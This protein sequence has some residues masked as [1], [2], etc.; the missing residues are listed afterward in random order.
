[1]QSALSLA[2]TKMLA[3]EGPRTMFKPTIP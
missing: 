2:R 3:N 1:M